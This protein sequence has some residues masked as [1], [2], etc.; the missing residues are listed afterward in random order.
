MIY[1]E[2]NEW[3]LKF[4]TNPKTRKSPILD[5]IYDLDKREQIKVFKYID[6]LREQGGILDEPYSRHIKGKIRELR[7][8]LARNRFRI[9]YFLY[10]GKTI[11]LLHAFKK[12][13]QKTPMNELMKAEERLN[14]V[15][16]YW[17]HYEKK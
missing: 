13:S 17:E 9:F 2:H 8:D 14:E 7:V 6:Y 4:Y 3:S 12:D 11:V 15:I 1:T 16:D 10:I 5:F